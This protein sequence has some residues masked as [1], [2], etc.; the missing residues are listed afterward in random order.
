MPLV[1]YE[2]PCDGLLHGVREC[3]QK[4]QVQIEQATKLPDFSDS[5]GFNT[6]AKSQQSLHSQPLIRNIGAL[7]S[8]RIT[9]EWDA[10]AITC[11]S[12]GTALNSIESERVGRHREGNQVVTDANLHH[13]ALFPKHCPS[14]SVPGFFPP[15]VHLIITRDAYLA[16]ELEATNKT[17]VARQGTVEFRNICAK[18]RAHRGVEEWRI[19]ES[20]RGKEAWGATRSNTRKQ[21]WTEKNLGEEG[22]GEERDGRASAP[23][24]AVSI[25]AYGKMCS[26][27]CGGGKGALAGNK[28]RRRSSLKTNGKPLRT[29]EPYESGPALLG[30]HDDDN[31]DGQSLTKCWDLRCEGVDGGH[32]HTWHDR[33]EY[34]AK[35]AADR[36]K[37]L[38]VVVLQQEKLRVRA[39]P[40]LF[41]VCS[42]NENTLAAGFSNPGVATGERM[43]GCVEG[44]G[45]GGEAAPARRTGAI[46]PGVGERLVSGGLEVC[47]RGER[48]WVAESVRIAE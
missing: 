40:A 33:H 31:K 10:A 11:G 43:A 5:S 48:S 1:E 16:N 44:E 34:S 3:E 20:G 15:D 32:Q 47:F 4:T 17:Q 13:R 25:H 27:Q 6:G 7:K 28:R 22:G 8:S 19:D 9:S 36:G 42:V 30:A 41:T 39:Y 14:R 35:A 26:G 29:S 23:H 46:W 2:F 12:T 18:M 37:P 38:Q 24:S 21:G 45:G